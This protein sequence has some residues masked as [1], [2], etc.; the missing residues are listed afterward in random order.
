MEERVVLREGFV[1]HRRICTKSQECLWKYY[2]SIERTLSTWICGSKNPLRVYVSIY[3]SYVKT[4]PS[5]H[6]IHITC[7]F[8]S[9]LVALCVWSVAFLLLFWCSSAWKT[10]IFWGVEFNPHAP[11]APWEWPQWFA[12]WKSSTGKRAAIGNTITSSPYG[13]HGQ[14]PKHWVASGSFPI[15]RV[16]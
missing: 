12:D 7:S 11:I 10:S 1:F 5:W 4:I 9:C 13:P 16:T 6:M 8:C 15:N 14:H 3:F 2:T